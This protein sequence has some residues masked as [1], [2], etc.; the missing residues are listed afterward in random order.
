MNL[1]LAV[2][3]CALNWGQLGVKTRM[4][5]VDSVR[6]CVGKVEKQELDEREKRLH[7]FYAGA[8]GCISFQQQVLPVEKAGTTGLTISH[9]DS[10]TRCGYKP[11]ERVYVKESE[12]YYWPSVILDESYSNPHDTEHE[13][14]FIAW[15]K[16]E[17]YW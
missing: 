8:N 9:T 14:C 5:C 6:E 3:L 7:T 10:I 13:K 4:E 16:K 1:Q 17:G 11:D 15:A 12:P 2:G